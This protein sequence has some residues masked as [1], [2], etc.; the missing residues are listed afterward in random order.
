MLH[1]W[2]YGQSV[3]IP[4]FFLSLSP[5]LLS[6]FLSFFLPFSFFLSFF[7]FLFL[8][9]FLFFLSF[10]LSSFSFFLPFSFF[11][12]FFLLF[13]FF[14]SF[15]LLSSWRAISTDIP[16]PP[17]LYLLGSN[18]GVKWM[19]EN[20]LHWNEVFYHHYHHVVPS[21]RISLTLSR[22]PSQSST[23]SGRSSGLHAVST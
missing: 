7:L 12:S 22:H 17:W 18:L 14:L 21:A 15:F 11:L 19:F 4:H 23:A 13:S 8:S 2:R 10:F 1:F 3:V 5:F 9:S 6:F 16:G 20:H